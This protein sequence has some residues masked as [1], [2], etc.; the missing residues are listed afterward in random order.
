MTPQP[1]ETKSA[2]DEI[3]HL[4]E[5]NFLLRCRLSCWSGNFQKYQSYKAN[6]V[7]KVPVQQLC[8]EY[9]CFSN[10]NDEETKKLM[11]LVS[12]RPSQPTDEQIQGIANHWQE[13]YKNDGGMMLYEA[14][15]QAILSALALR[16]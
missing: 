9:E 8:E 6:G 11:A 1:S 13:L 4:K 7:K 10:M 16:K 14:I 3:E 2:E 12:V 5:Q 15:K